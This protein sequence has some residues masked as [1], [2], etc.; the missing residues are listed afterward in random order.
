MC[1]SQATFPCVKTFICSENN[2]SQSK[3]SIKQTLAG[4][5]T[6]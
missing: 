3:P 1:Y 4:Y 6:S 5:V 2:W